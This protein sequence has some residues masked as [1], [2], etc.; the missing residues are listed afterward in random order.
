MRAKVKG[1]HTIYFGDVPMKGE[2]R[3]IVED[4]NYSWILLCCITFTKNN[5]SGINSTHKNKNYPS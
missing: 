2:E 3:D 1:M 4:S 5:N